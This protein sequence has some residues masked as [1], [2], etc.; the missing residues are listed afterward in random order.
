MR[1]ERV[2]LTAL[3][4]GPLR[5]ASFAYRA[6]APRIAFDQTGFEDVRAEG[7][8]RFSRAAVTVPILFTARRVTGV[9]DVAG[10]ILAN[11]RVQGLLKVTARQLTGEGLTLT[12]DK[13]KS[14]LSLF[15]DLVTGRYDVVLSGGLSRYLIPGLGIV[16]VLTE[17]KVVPN[18]AGGARS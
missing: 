1:G 18:P 16:D 11:L 6:T 13:L 2:R 9:G 8:G 7:R 3:L 10:G 12:S 5:S 15:V 17:L 4:N 14:K